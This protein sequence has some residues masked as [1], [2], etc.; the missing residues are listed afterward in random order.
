[1]VLDLRLSVAP[2]TTPVSLAE[3]KA[4]ANITSDDEDANLQAY[5]DAAVGHL[6]GYAGILGRALMT[7]TWVLSLERFP[8][9]FPYGHL[10]DPS[11]RRSRHP[12][13]IHLP[14]PPLVS[15]ASIAYVDPD[16]ASQTLAADQY[17]VLDGPL[18]AID[19]APGC[20]WPATRRQARAVTI[21]FVCGYGAATAVPPA[22]KSA[23][24]LLFSDFAENREG[25]VIGTREAQIQNP[26]L[27]NLLR[28]LIVPKV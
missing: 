22:A 27:M 25:N 14:L 19:L 18:A 8:S 26:A 20:S 7:Q 12:R 24:K 11:V 4:H 21:T 15:V 2:T 6:D 5:L 17:V 28:D 3:A 16:G 1:M 9:A 10:A 23:I 13:R